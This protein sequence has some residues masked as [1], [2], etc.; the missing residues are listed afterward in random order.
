[1]IRIQVGSL[2]EQET[3]RFDE[4]CF[5]DDEF[6]ERLRPVEND[7]VDKYVRGELPGP[8]LERFDAH[9]LASPIRREKVKTARAF[10]LHA[11]S[12]VA[13][14]KVVFT[15]G[16]SEMNAISDSNIPKWTFLAGFRAFPRLILT[17]AAILVLV[18]LGWMVFELSRLR[19]Q[20]DRAQATRTALEQREKELRE[21]LERQR[22]AS[23]ATE[24]ELE[25]VREERDR[26]ERQMALERQITKSQSPA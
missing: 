20:V 21:S 22:Q 26:L 6:V 10:Q 12:V 19:S 13:T 16:P 4:L 8:T 9:Y 3:E 23:L 14:G 1:M 15:P 7:L 25:R 24:K 18:G 2:P 17:S 11:E 5:V